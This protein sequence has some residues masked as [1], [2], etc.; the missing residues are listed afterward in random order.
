MSSGNRRDPLAPWDLSDL[1]IS[2]EDSVADV[3][4]TL[5]RFAVLAPSG[6]NTQPWRFAILED[7]IDVIADRNRRLA[8]VDPDD[9][10]LVISVGAAVGTLEVAAH[11][12]GYEA[13]VDV[14]SDPAEPDILASISLR[15]AASSD[16]DLFAAIPLRRSTRKPFESR[17]LEPE[18]IAQ[19]KTDVE[20]FDVLISVIH[21]EARF[22]IAELIAE[23]DAIQ[24]A[25][26][27]FRKELVSWMRP[28]KSDANDGMR[29]YAFGFSDLM[30][31]ATPLVIRTFDMGKM[32]GARDRELATGSPALLLLA[33]RTDDEE[34]WL[35]TGRAL[36]RVLLRL[37]ANGATA[38]FLNQ[39]IE[40]A[41]L[42]SRLVAAAGTSGIP[43]LLLRAGYGPLIKA[44]PRRPLEQALVETKEDQR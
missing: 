37:T 38:S 41:A 25:N 4:W 24:M 6:H 19:L 2:P 16:H 20:L 35:A 34:R 8:V 9:R 7:R 44:E 11:H 27:D 42:R 29:G 1:E 14:L 32:Q 23:G 26:A 33:T 5:L 21:G 15:R 43:Q 17:D 3:A 40:V 10:A 31:H 36:V 28:N 13:D 22:P 12:F 39:P 18:L 30:S